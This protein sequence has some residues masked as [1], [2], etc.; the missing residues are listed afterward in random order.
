MRRQKSG[1]LHASTLRRLCAS[2][3]TFL[4]IWGPAAADPLIRIAVVNF[5]EVS[6]AYLAFQKNLQDNDAKRDRI[7]NSVA[8][9]N[10]E[11]RKME[12]SLKLQR[13]PVRLSTQQAL[14]AQRRVELQTFYY[15]SMNILEKEREE[16][17]A[18]ARKTIYNAIKQIAI[19]DGFS[20]VFSENEILY[21]AEDYVDMTESVIRKL[22]DRK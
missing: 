14:I 4:C 1:C 6:M 22:N 21:A 15:Q 18:N 13:D 7:L 2:A 20:L 16:L 5:E 11:I 19:Q 9:E 3:V 10:E 8:A 12:E 17:I